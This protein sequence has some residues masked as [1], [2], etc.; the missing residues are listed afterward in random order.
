M[1]DYRTLLVQLL[2]LPQENSASRVCCLVMPSFAPEY[3]V[4]VHDAGARFDLAVHVAARSV[5]AHLSA[6]RGVQHVE[7]LRGWV[8]PGVSVER[9]ETTPCDG[10]RAALRALE[11]AEE[12]K[13]SIFVDGITVAIDAGRFRREGALLASSPIRRFFDATRDLALRGA[14]WEMSRSALCR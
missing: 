4:L 12:P 10:W 3:A 9:F 7:P 1:N 14:T 2:E 8:R 5:W 6:G 13:D 11:E